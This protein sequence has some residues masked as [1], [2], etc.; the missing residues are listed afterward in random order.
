[1]PI[2][3]HRGRTAV[4]R[5]LWGWPLRSPKHLAGA[6]VLVVAVASGVGLLLA[7]V[8]SATSPPGSAARQTERDYESDPREGLSGGETG[9]TSAETREV[10]PPSISVPNVEPSSVQPD[11]AGLEVVREWFSAWTRSSED[12]T[13][14]QWIERLRPYTTPEFIGVMNTV[15]PANVPATEVTGQLQVDES[16]KTSMR[17]RVPTDG[18]TVRVH[19]VRSSSEGWR[20]SGYDRVD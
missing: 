14:E 10:S 20:V 1:M 16:T 4:Y 15:D 5:R 6:V 9:D 8:P 17:V 19:V 11:P 7:S 3:T 13:R 18:P 2:R 12:T